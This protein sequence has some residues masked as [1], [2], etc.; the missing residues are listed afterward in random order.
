MSV[1]STGHIP[2]EKGPK[3]N[4][5][6]LEAFEYQTKFTDPENFCAHI[7]WSIFGDVPKGLSIDPETGKI[8]GV[9]KAFFDQPSANDNNP[10]EESEFDGSNWEKDGR[11]KHPFFD[12]HFTIQRDIFIS[13]LNPTTNQMDCSFKVHSI[14]SSDV[15]IRVIKCHN[16]SNLVFI[17]RYLET[18]KTSPVLNG[19]TKIN[20][21]GIEYT[22][23]KSCAIAMGLNPYEKNI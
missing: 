9:I 19:K 7:V 5:R 6:E 20:I 18:T 2:N 14:E 23:W 21:K 4:P 12:F 1:D 8:S 15:F 3:M 11:F 10:Y 17:K 22:D 13:G 16:V